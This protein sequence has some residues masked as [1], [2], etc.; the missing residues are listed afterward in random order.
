MLRR[1]WF[2]FEIAQ[3]SPLSFGCGVTAYDK[4]DA[5]RTLRERV[6][7]RT[8]LTGLSS[9]DVAPITQCIED[10]DVRTLDQ[11]HVVPNMGVVPC[12]GVWFPGSGCE[13]PLP[14]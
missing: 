10:V 12:R 5:I 9:T 7:A 4:D 3:T 14:D 6:F 11:N 8:W 13:A 2:N 1:Y